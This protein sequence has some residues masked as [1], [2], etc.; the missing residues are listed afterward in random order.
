MVQ[1]WRQQLRSKRAFLNT[2]A[3]LALQLV[4]IICGFIIPR[5]VIET[6]GSSVN[7]LV[8]SITQFLGIISLLE[9]GIGGVVRA[10]LYK[11]LADNNVSNISAI[12][13]V[14]ENFFKKLA[15]IFVVYL[16]TIASILPL[17]VIND[18]DK[19]F[20]FTLVIIVGTSIFAQYFFGITYQILLQAD[21]RLYVSSIYNI[22]TIIMS[23][24]IS[25]ILINLGATIHVVKLSTAFIF[26]LRPILLQHYVKRKYRL[27][28]DYSSIFKGNDLLNQRWSG[29]GHHIAYFVHSSTGIIVLTLFSNVKEISVYSIYMMI[30]LGIQN[31]TM[32][33][34]SGID[35]AFGN[36]IAKGEISTLKKNFSLFE[37]FSFIV[38]TILFTSTA[39]LILPFVTIYTKGIIDVDYYRPL[40]SYILI[41]TEAVYCIRLPYHYIVMAAGHFKQTRNGALIEAVINVGLSIILVKNW[42]IVGVA[43]G[44]LCAIIFRT[45][46]YVWYL[47]RNILKRNIGFFIKRVLVNLC[48]VIIIVILF[49]ISTNFNINTY[50]NWFYYMVGV[51]VTTT[52]ITFLINS[53]F[54]H[55][56]MKNLREII[57]RVLK[58]NY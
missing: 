54:Y 35:A 14:A 40:F 20:T 42:G 39:L 13:K 15:L 38:T 17:L 28:D 58:I 51:V 18:F 6:Y 55:E 45:I 31:L 10:V 7:G 23:T 25:V 3:S 52:I 32:T 24:I 53:F 33:F 56:D 47:S 8:S 27:I 16:L 30:V 46:Q 49:T 19:L 4:T 11:P 50:V 37:F 48:A 5:L 41:A 29:I 12:L 36:M 57:N 9:G 43:C 34:S 21:Q 26:I 2:L 22:F 44:A 1:K